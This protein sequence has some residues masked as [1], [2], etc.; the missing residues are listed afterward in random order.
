MTEL[1]NELH[2][3]NEGL[4]REVLA[5]QCGDLLEI[6]DLL[7]PFLPATAAKIKGVFEE[8]IARPLET[9]LFPKFETQ[10]A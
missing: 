9:T 2:E 5:Q 4:V 7:E 6:A 8:G 1:L 10:N 3:V